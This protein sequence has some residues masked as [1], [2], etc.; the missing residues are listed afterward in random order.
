[1]NLVT[2]ELVEP[3]KNLPRAVVIGP[4]IVIVAYL[5]TNIAYYALLD[6][7]VIKT[8]TSIAMDF[9]RE[10]FGHAGSIIIPLAVVGSTFSA[11][12]AGVFTGARVVYV[13]ARSGHAP[14]LLGEINA[15]TGLKLHILQPGTPINAIVQQAA[16][17]IIFVMVGNFNQLVNLYSMIAWTFYL[18]AVSCLII[19]RFKAFFTLA[20]YVSRNL[21]S[22]VL[23]VYGGSHQSCFALHLRF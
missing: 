6:A 16:T 21:I 20:D 22:T 15:K 4:G 7:S 18:L 23:I 3:S 17:S 14:R 9:G 10:A 5:V 8:S 1:M 12:N 11:A 19:L 13:S 2:E